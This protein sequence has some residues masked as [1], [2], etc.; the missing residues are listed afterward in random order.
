M[1]IILNS[2]D[3][4]TLIGGGP[5]EAA[6]L[7]R[8]V[9]F[10]PMVIA[11][12]GGVNRAA[13]LDQKVA[14]VIGDMDSA[15][16]IDGPKYHQIPDQNTTDL[17][18]CLYA[19]TAPFYLGVGFLGGRLDHHLAACHSLLCAPDKH[20]ILLGEQD[21][22]FLAGRE[23]TLSLP[24]GTRISLF[25]MGTVSGISEGLKYPLEGYDFAPDSKIST[26]NEVVG[27]VKLS[28]NV[29]KMLVVLPLAHLER[30]IETL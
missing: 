27:E 3:P 20:V 7:A 12:D 8:A 5:V 1:S 21:L 4:I 29:R 28:F 26:S 11:A 9:G 2:P 16:R 30:V 23:M 22:C 14:H 17:D 13:A 18:K 15:R 6:E 10:A 24:L 19:T 25:P